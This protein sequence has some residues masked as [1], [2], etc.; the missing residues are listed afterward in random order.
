MVDG[1]GSN[2][3][4]AT[5]SA[6]IAS[7]SP[8]KETV[9]KNQEQG[10]SHLGVNTE[11]TSTTYTAQDR[12]NKPF[13]NTSRS[14]ES[15][16]PQDDTAVES[17]GQGANQPGATTDTPSST[18]TTAN[19]LALDSSEKSFTN[20]STFVAPADSRDDTAVESQEHRDGP[21]QA[22]SDTLPISNTVSTC[23]VLDSSDKSSANTSTSEE[24]SGPCA[25]NAAKNQEQGDGQ[26]GDDT[27]TL[28]INHTI[29]TAMALGSSNKSTSESTEDLAS[30]EANKEASTTGKQSAPISTYSVDDVLI[31]ISYP[32]VGTLGTERYQEWIPFHAA[33]YAC[34]QSVW[35]QADICQK[36]LAKV[37]EHGGCFL[38]LSSQHWIKLGQSASIA[39]VGD[40]LK[41]HAKRNKYTQDPS[42]H[43]VLFGRGSAVDH[44][45]GNVQFRL[46]I[47]QHA[48]PALVHSSTF[49]SICQ[50]LVAKVSAA[51][52]SFFERATDSIWVKMKTK[53]RREKVIDALHQSYS[54]QATGRKP[55]NEAN[56]NTHNN[57]HKT[58][59][60]T[61]PTGTGAV[62][63]TGN[64]SSKQQDQCHPF[65]ERIHLSEADS[66]VHQPEKVISQSQVT[67]LDVLAGVKDWPGNVYY[68]Q[69][70]RLLQEDKDHPKD[71]RK[72]TEAAMRRVVH[73]G[74]RFLKQ[75][76]ETSSTE[77]T[78]ME[79]DQ[80][81]L[82]TFFFGK[83]LEHRK[84]IEVI[85]LTKE[86]VMEMPNGRLPA[87]KAPPQGK[88]APSGQSMKQP[89]QRDVL[90]GKGHSWFSSWRGNLDC[91]QLIQHY[92][93]CC[94]AYAPEQESSRKEFIARRVMH[95]I[96]SSGGGF[97]RLLHNDGSSSPECFEEQPCVEL[98][99]Q[100][101]LAWMC[102][103]IPD[104]NVMHQAFLP[105]ASV[106]P[107][108]ADSG[109]RRAEA[110]IIRNS[111]QPKCDREDGRKS[112][113]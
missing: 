11:T 21:A 9:V 83:N 98:D 113:N 104:W 60:R 65:A 30:N 69:Q 43:D 51:G 14:A 110:A 32:S 66:R 54:I 96:S 59:Q 85:D 101:V 20:A 40:D 106:G 58:A 23:S 74:G 38:Q 111:E 93:W 34:A 42:K 35:E 57:P 102:R 56:K 26:P 37:R 39:K 53:K 94:P 48:V 70:L 86:P 72:V 88:H 6:S 25:D 75:M 12:D 108:A 45:P 61:G 112:S 84:D 18:H 1:D 52:G 82:L 31:G 16:V 10:G 89:S 71:A 79:V 27:E 55:R 99:A 3:S 47:Q 97:L 92:S 50:Q 73:R 77:K 87:S 109:Q 63:V 103:W 78:W 17:Q 29:T 44:H 5:A 19:A 67:D 33:E 81:S 95:D 13:A 62:T 100:S 28:S 46:W 24:S 91:A 68:T 49:S 90:F 76:N 2:K 107:A 15:S 8:C 80:S 41:A 36:V 64:L 105:P 4:F 7:S 22:I